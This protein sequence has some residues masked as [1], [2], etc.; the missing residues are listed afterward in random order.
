MTEPLPSQQSA[1]LLMQGEPL[2]LFAV[3]AHAAGRG[4]LIYAGA[5]LF[6]AKAETAAKAAI[7]GALVIEAF[8][9]AHEF[10]GASGGLT[11]EE[12]MPSPSTIQ[13]I[14]APPSVVKIPSGWR[15]PKE[16]TEVPR[17]A[18]SR[19]SQFLYSSKMGE[20]E[21]H[22]SWGLIKEWHYDDHVSPGTK[23]WH[24]GISVLLPQ[25]V[26]L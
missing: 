10:K 23:K 25:T 12:L 13:P 8:V 11:T 26:T 1:R 4:A 3:V 16:Q 18:V 14:N 5:L 15:Y 20:F 17:E 22:E 19:A 24:P 9:L 21:D 6:G 7:G 2:A